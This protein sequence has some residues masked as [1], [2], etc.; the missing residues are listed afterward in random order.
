M[1][2]R[3]LKNMR[4]KK[5]K[6]IHSFIFERVSKMKKLYLLAFL[7]IPVLLVAQEDRKKPMPPEREGKGKREKKAITKEEWMRRGLERFKKMDKNGDGFITKDERP[8]RNKKR[9]FRKGGKE[10]RPDR[11]RRNPS[12]LFKRMD[13]DGD[14]KISREE[15]RGPERLFKYLDKN[16]DGVI[17]LEEIHGVKDRPG[18]KEKKGHHL[19]KDGDG[20]VSQKEFLQA[21]EALFKRL[22][23]NQDGKLDREEL[24]ALRKF[25]HMRKKMKFKKKVDHFFRRMDKNGDG[26][27]SKDEVME[28]ARQ[29]FDK[30][31]LDGDGKITKEEFMK[32]LRRRFKHHRGAGK[33]GFGRGNGG[34]IKRADN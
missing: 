32:A 16:Q 3:S 13:K 10:D 12:A 1:R 24:R 17:T 5:L 29:H 18:R 34:N 30:I 21:H 20:K 28:R 27:I 4:V 6:R 15:W 11:P 26:V 23:K 9:P 14:G 7:L 22:D 2:K 31:D 25:H 33:G 19:D 8:K